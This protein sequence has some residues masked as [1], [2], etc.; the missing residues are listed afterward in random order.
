VKRRIQ[1]E[2]RSYLFQTHTRTS[3]FFLPLPLSRPPHCDI[4][5]TGKMASSA[6]PDYAIQFSDSLIQCE[7]TLLTWKGNSPDPKIIKAFITGE[8]HSHSL[9]LHLFPASLTR[10]LPELF[11]RNLDPL[12]LDRFI[13][14]DRVSSR[15]PLWSLDPIP[16]VQLCNPSFEP[17]V[18]GHF[19]EWRVGAT[20]EVGW[21]FEKESGTG[22]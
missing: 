10:S 18:C 21:V 11:L 5:H 6:P 13:R 3:L 14:I 17:Y 20:W 19:G 22:S 16:T 1:H 12:P 2:L 9:P 7:P 15:R 4:R 8:V